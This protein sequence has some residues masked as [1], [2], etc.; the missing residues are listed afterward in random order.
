MQDRKQ[1]VQGMDAGAV[2][3]PL[4]EKRHYLALMLMLGIW[5]ICMEDRID[6]ID[7]K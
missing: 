6:R 4:D 3:C 2:L 7:P 5:G 1:K